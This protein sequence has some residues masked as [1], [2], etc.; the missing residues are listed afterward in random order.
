MLTELEGARVF[1]KPDVTSGFWQVPRHKD[2]M[3]LTTFITP[4]GHHYFKRLLFGISSAAEHFQKRISQL[5]DSI[6]GVL[7]HADHVLV[8]GGTGPNMMNGCKECYRS[9]EKLGSL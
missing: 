1:T 8:T 6:D 7:C 3:L 2:S 5:I 4:E 9:S